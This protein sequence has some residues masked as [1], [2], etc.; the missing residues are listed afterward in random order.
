M[1]RRRNGLLAAFCAV[2]LALAGCGGSKDYPSRP[3]T[4]VVPWG[5]GGG[6]DAIARMIA[7]LMERDLG[8]PINVVNRTGGNGVI[9]H[10]AVASAPP[11]GYTLGFI[12]TEIAMLHWQGLTPLTPDDF[13]P[14]AL[15]NFDPAGVQVRADSKYATLQDLLDDIRKRPGRIKATGCGQGCIWHVSFFGLLADKKIDPGSVAWV[16]SNGAAPGLLDLVAGGVEVVPCSLPEARSLI[17]AGKVRSLA[18]MDA[19]RAPLFPDVPTLQEAVASGWTL[20]AWRGVAGPKGM[21][22]P[23]VDRLAASLK[24]VYEAREYRDFMASRGFGLLWGDA[25]QFAE[26]MKQSNAAMGRTM[27]VVGIINR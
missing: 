2:L 4:I 10:Q 19:K 25:R 9:G 23:I 13:T 27:T 16:P 15:M 17:E 8:Q 11:D 1:I 14:I 6:T 24:K 22:Q 7:S 20:G 18:I 12:T 5:A 21:P 26:H 3:I